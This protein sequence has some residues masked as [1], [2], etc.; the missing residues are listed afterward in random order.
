MIKIVPD[1]NVLLSGMFGKPESAPRTVLD[2]ALAKRVVMYGSQETYEEFCEKVTIP[3]FARYW[4]RKMFSPEKI[5]LDYKAI[6]SIMD[7]R[8]FFEGINIVERDPS[9]DCYYKTA[10]SSG[11]KIIVTGDKHLLDIG[12]YEGIIAVKP[13]KFLSALRARNSGQL[14]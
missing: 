5:I 2:L 12:K 3:K 13:A 9:D 7:T 8:G 1:A 14:F 6:V 10:K 4:K 11:A